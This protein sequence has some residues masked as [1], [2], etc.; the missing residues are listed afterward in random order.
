MR[1][2]S[3]LPSATEILYALGLGEA[4]V[5][6]P[7]SVGLLPEVFLLLAGEETLEVFGAFLRTNN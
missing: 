5:G 6:A 4:V 3:F 7:R 1:I 2:C